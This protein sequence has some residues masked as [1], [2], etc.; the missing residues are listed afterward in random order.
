MR[1]DASGV[2]PVPVVVPDETGGAPAT[3]GLDDPAV[4]GMRPPTASTAPS[5]PTAGA[6]ADPEV[7]PGPATA[8]A[9][10]P[11]TDAAGIMLSGLPAGPAT[12]GVDNA[13]GG[14]VDTGGTVVDGIT[15]GGLEPVLDVTSGGVEQTINEL[16]VDDSIVA[17]VQPALDALPPIHAGAQV[18]PL[19]AGPL[20]LTPPVA[21]D[22][23]AGGGS[24]GVS[25]DAGSAQLS[26]G[27]GG[28]DGVRVDLP[29]AGTSSA[30]AEP[31][32][33]DAEILPRSCHDRR[34]G[35]CGEMTAPLSIVSRRETDMRRPTASPLIAIAATAGIATVLLLPAL[36]AAAPPDGDGG[37]LGI[38]APINVGGNGI[39]ILGGS[40][41]GSASPPP[42]TSGG[43]GGS[44]IDLQ[45][46][47][48]V[49]GN[50]VSVAGTATPAATP[51]ARNRR[52]PGA[53]GWCRCKRPSTSAATRWAP[54]AVP[55]RPPRRRRHRH[56]RRCRRRPV[57]RAGSPT[58]TRRSR[59]VATQWAPSVTPAPRARPAAAESAG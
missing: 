33:G 49:G 4:P 44:L 53:G 1:A 11:P 31:G 45:V 13:L 15:G 47:I 52:L 22:A 48:T 12:V 2:A 59:C 41:E 35:V 37:L 25:A 43:G 29:G 57:R 54:S 39:G 42:A 9:L 3:P 32:A 28:P 7:V 10:P 34:G 51:P 56:P 18:A 8:P 17:A 20:D 6:V 16:G 46:P 55:A 36:A 23:D 26:V 40:A 19:S 58:S 50:G 21:V 38:D 14:L 27:V 5:T 30:A 24:V